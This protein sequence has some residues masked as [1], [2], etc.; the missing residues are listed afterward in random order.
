MGKERLYRKRLIIDERNRV[1]L[2][3]EL[4]DELKM[5]KGQKVCI[6]ANFEEN[7]IVIKKD[8]K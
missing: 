1:T 6:Y 2:P 8:E 3:E 4:L 7:K 5:K